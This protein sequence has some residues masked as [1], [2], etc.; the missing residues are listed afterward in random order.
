MKVELIFDLYEFLTVKDE[1]KEF[2]EFITEDY[3]EF[4]K[5][6]KIDTDHDNFTTLT[7]LSKK[8]NKVNFLPQIHFDDDD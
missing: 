4:N 2:D 7:K 3:D 8:I 6:Y 5:T 1:M